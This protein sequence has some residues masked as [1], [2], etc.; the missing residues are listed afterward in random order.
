M[1]NIIYLYLF[2]S[3]LSNGKMDV[4]NLKYFQ[5]SEQSEREEKGKK[6]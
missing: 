5:K 2:F 6:S 4:F 1:I 3:H